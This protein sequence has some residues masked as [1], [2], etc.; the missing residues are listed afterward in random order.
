M[1][2]NDDVVHYHITFDPDDLR[3]RLD[4]SGFETV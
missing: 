1:K 2:L 3:V 4:V